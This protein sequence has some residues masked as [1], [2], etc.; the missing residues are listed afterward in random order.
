MRH[1]G[2]I[3]RCCWL[4]CSR[5]FIDNVIL[6]NVGNAL[7]CNNQR[8]RGFIL[9][10]DTLLVDQLKAVVNNPLISFIHKPFLKVALPAV[11]FCAGQL[12]TEELGAFMKLRKLEANFVT[13]LEMR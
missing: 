12:F 3:T 7:Q 10:L 6:R 8:D 2:D 4:N 1:G 13:Y 5:R 9:S 11:I